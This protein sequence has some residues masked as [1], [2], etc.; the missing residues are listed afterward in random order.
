MPKPRWKLEPPKT[1]RL[2]LTPE[3][4]KRYKALMI[5]KGRTMQEDLETYIINLLN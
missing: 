2:K 5:S 3:T 1:I 4:L